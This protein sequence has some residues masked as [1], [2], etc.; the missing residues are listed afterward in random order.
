MFVRVLIALIFAIATIGCVE[1]K[2]HLAE[3]E[4]SLAGHASACFAPA[5]RIGDIDAC[6]QGRG[7]LEPG[8]STDNHRVYTECEPAPSVGR[9][10]NCVGL[11]IT[12]QWPSEPKPGMD[13]I[14][15]EDGAAVSWKIL[16][17][18]KFAGAPRM[19]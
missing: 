17:Y 1:R 18:D 8:W 6:M 13:A 19:M 7:F 3:I 16:V 12:Y 15:I 2:E 5:R 14:T 4:T 10:L 9:S 11:Y